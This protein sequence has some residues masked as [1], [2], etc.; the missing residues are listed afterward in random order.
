LNTNRIHDLFLRSLHRDQ[1]APEPKPVIDLQA[2]RPVAD[3]PATTV[4]PPARPPTEIQP[5]RTWVDAAFTETDVY[6][7]AVTLD[8]PAAP[9]DRYGPQEA[10]LRLFGGQR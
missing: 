7:E 3:E 2:A 1:P 4:A 10:A 8:E 6:R 5:R 9:T